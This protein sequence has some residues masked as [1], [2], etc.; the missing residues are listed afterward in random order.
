MLL[1][2]P[3][4][5]S[6][7]PTPG[8][9]CQDLWQAHTA[10]GR[11]SQQSPWPSCPASHN[12]A[13]HITLHYITSH[14]ITSTLLW[15]PLSLSGPTHFNEKCKVEEV[16]DRLHHAV[17]VHLPHHTH[18]HILTTTDHRLP[19]SLILAHQEVHHV[20]APGL[21]PS[22]RPPPSLLQSSEQRLDALVGGLR[23]ARCVSVLKHSRAK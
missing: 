18:Q 5:F 12:T 7:P 16:L 22:P 15:C 10:A 9:A 21:C 6:R 3:F 17:P 8:S 19:L 13:H 1:V 20:N 23:L 14:H 11:S 4:A 2:S